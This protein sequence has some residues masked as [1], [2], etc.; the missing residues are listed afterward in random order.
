[1]VNRVPAL[2]IRG[3][4]HLH[5]L[6][7]LKQKVAGTAGILALLRKIGL[8]RGQRRQEERPSQNSVRLWPAFQQPEKVQGHA[9]L[10][11]L[12]LQ[13]R[14]H[15]ER[16]AVCGDGYATIVKSERPFRTR[17]PFDLQVRGELENL[18]D[19]FIGKRT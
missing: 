14:E 1:M 2:T 18:L 17:A 19:G 3:L 9:L 11:F 6:F 13:L 7:R 8:A 15:F 5:R 10:F 4:L 16:F 12:S